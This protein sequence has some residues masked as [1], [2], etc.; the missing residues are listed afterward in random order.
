MFIGAFNMISFKTVRYLNPRMCDR[1][2]DLM[3]NTGGLDQ[4]YIKKSED[5]LKM[6][7][8]L[9]QV[10][11]ESAKSKLTVFLTRLEKHLVKDR[12][13]L[14]IKGIPDKGTLRDTGVTETI[15]YPHMRDTMKQFG[16]FSR[17]HLIRGTLY[18]QFRHETSCV[19][20]HTLL[21]NMQM[22]DNIIT[23]E[24]VS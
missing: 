13:N 15:G 18:V 14:I 16:S 2:V 6:I 11:P 8:Q 22:G 17:M 1:M 21:N 19:Q 4:E 20:C 5:V 3:I 10:K 7:H 12:Y 24:V 9:A 23:T